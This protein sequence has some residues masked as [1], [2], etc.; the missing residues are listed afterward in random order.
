MLAAAARDLADDGVVFLGINSRDPNTAPVR[1]FVEQL[2]HPLRQ[3][4]RPRRHDAARLPRHPAAAWRSR[5]SCS[6]TPTV[7]SPRA[8]SDEVSSS[9]LYGVVEDVLGR[10]RCPTADGVNVADWFVE[11]VTSGTMLLAVPG[12]GWPPGT[13]SFFS[14]C[15]VPLLPGYVSYATGLSGADL[16]TARRGRM[17]AGTSCSSSASP[18]GSWW[19]APPPGRWASGCASTSARSAWCSG[20]LTIVVGLVFMGLVPWLQR[21]VRVHRGPRSGWPLRRCSGCSSR[22]A[23]PRAWGRRSPRCR[24]GL[25]EGTAGRGALLSV[26]YSLGLGH[27]VHPARAGLPPDA[28]RGPV[29]PPPPGL[30]DPVRRAHARRGRRA[31][32]HRLVGPVGRRAARLGRRLRGAGLVAHHRPDDRAAARR[33]RSAPPP[34]LS[35]RSCCAGPGAS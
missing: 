23:G 6:S 35:P 32:G 24:H 7:G 31:A 3:H 21:D 1:R 10:T 16:E 19:S 27:A 8:S 13:V 12:G 11:Q 25:T 2:R 20:A 14:P 4:L 18:S 9:T 33:H 5:P 17:L 15:V 29:G 22:S 26:A 30:G 28:G 34:A